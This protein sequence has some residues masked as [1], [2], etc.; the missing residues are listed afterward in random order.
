MYSLLRIGGGEPD[1]IAWCFVLEGTQGSACGFWV[2]DTAITI[3]THSG[4]TAS[5]N[6]VPLEALRWARVG[7]C[8]GTSQI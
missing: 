2:D 5:L 3:P 7:E 8:V 6:K 1:S 4:G